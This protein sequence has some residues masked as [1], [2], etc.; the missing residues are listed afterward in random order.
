MIA[1]P[2]ERLQPHCAGLAD[3]YLAYASV[4]TLSDAFL[5]TRADL[6]ACAAQAETL[7]QWQVKGATIEGGGAAIPH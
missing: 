2:D 6:G 3:V 5:T 7:W 1:K 4:G